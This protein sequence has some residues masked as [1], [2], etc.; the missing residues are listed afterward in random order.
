MKRSANIKR[1]CARKAEEIIRKAR[2]E[3]RP[4]VLMLSRPYHIDPQIHHKAPDIIT[5]FGVDVLTED[6]IPL[7]DDAKIENNHVVSLWQYV[8]RMLYAANWAGQQPDVE[9]VQINSF[10]C[11]PDAINIDEARE[12][13]QEWQKGFTVIRVDEIESTG[14]MRLRLRSM[15]ESMRRKQAAQRDQTGAST[16][17]PAP[18]DPRLPKKRPKTHHPGARFL[19]LRHPSHRPSRSRY[20]L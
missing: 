18:D 13:L 17:C 7:P 15:V 4:M 2:A 5:D 14:S 1:P 8:N 16:L 11:G 20:G 3:K 12:T 19:A 9:V 10:G 6:A